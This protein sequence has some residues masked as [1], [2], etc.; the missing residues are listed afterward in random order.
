MQYVY[1]KCY[2]EKKESIILE[3]DSSEAIVDFPAIINSLVKDIYKIKGVDCINKI[4]MA[5]LKDNQYGPN[6][7]LLYDDEKAIL[8]EKSEITNTGY[9][10]N[11][12]TPEIKKLFMWKLLSYKHL[13][14]HTLNIE[15]NLIEEIETTLELP[16]NFP[17]L[18]LDKKI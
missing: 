10:Y 9:L 13:N 16:A 5:I 15:P 1:E 4:D 17:Q 12:K 8:I 7:Y 14:N 18:G 11:Y 2:T 6:K 3:F